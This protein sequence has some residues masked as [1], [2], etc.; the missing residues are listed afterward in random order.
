RPPLV[1]GFV[2]GFAAAVVLASTGVLPAG[3]LAGAERVQ[4]VLVVAALVGLGTQIRWQ[5]LRRAG[6]RALLLGLGSWLLVAGT[7]Y[8]ALRLLGS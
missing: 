8:A 4:H 7:A 5:V 3:V 6:G 1:P 2:L